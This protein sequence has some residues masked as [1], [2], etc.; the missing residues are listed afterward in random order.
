[1]SASAGDLSNA[2]HGSTRHSSRPSI[3]TNASGI[4]ESTI[5]FSQ[6]PAVPTE[7]PT[8]PIRA[9]FSNS[10]VRSNFSPVQPLVP[11]RG[12]LSASTYRN[13]PA[14]A[15]SSRSIQPR[16]PSASSS[17]VRGNP[18]PTHPLSP[19]DWHDGS[20]SIDGIDTQEARLL[21]TSF[22]TSLLQEN[23]EL[24]RQQ[25]SS[26]ASDAFS[27][28]SEL[29]Y[30]PSPPYPQP[31]S[32]RP[33][34]LQNRTGNPNRTHGTSRAPPSA[35]SP[36]REAPNR[37]ST[38]D[39]ETLHSTQGH[40]SIAGYTPNNPPVVVGVAQATLRS[41]P[42]SSRPPSSQTVPLSV[43]EKE[44]KYGLSSQDMDDDSILRFKAQNAYYPPPDPTPPS[45]ATHRRPNFNPQPS[46]QARQSTYSLAPS[47]VSK[48]SMASVGRMFHWRKKSLPPV[49]RIPDIPLAVENQTRRADQS[50]PLP[51]L[52]NR[53]DTLHALLEKGY[54]PHHSLSSYQQYQLQQDFPVSVEG[55]EHSYHQ[56]TVNTMGTTNSTQPLRPQYYSDFADRT[57]DKPTLTF[58][59]QGSPARASRLPLLSKRMKMGIAIFI[60]AAVASIIAAIV[61]VV[62]RNQSALPNC[63]NGLTGATCTLNSTC[64]CT[65]DDSRC[66]P[67]ARN[68]IDLIPSVN[69]A[70]SSNLT[71]HD[72]YTSLW[73]SQGRTR[74]NDCSPQ[75]LLVD[76]G[77][78]LKEELYPTRTQWVRAALLWNVV[79]AQDLQSSEDMLKF[80]QS[81]PWDSLPGD[82]PTNV[83]EE[84]FTASFSGFIYNFAAQTVTPISA[85]FASQGQPTREQIARVG[86]T[87]QSTLDRMYT[88]A[89]ASSVQRELALRNYW[90]TTLSQKSEDL[91]VFKAL[92][93]A[94]PILLPFDATSSSIR[95]LFSN[96]SSSLFPPP[97][98]CYPGLS[99]QQR[100][101]LNSL[102]TSVFQLPASETPSNFGTGCYPD[103]PIYGVLDV[104]RLRLPFLDSRSDLP[105]QGAILH[106]DAVPRVVIHSGEVLSA[107]FPNSQAP[108]F[109]A[110]QLDP[111]NFGTLNFSN[112]V[113]LRYLT[114][115]PVDTAILLVQYLLGI[116]NRPQAP[117]APSSPLFNVLATVP[118]IEVSIFGAVGPPDVA[119]TVSALA[120]TSDS[121]FYGSD[122]AAALRR[123]TISGYGGTVH[124][125]ERADAPRIVKDDSFN[126]QVMNEAWEA[127]AESIRRDLF[128]LDALVSSFEST[129]KFV[130]A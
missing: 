109:D 9:G 60:I 58:S 119:G 108:S 1:M 122:P 11:R 26:F 76:S 45:N 129:G 5:S 93:S 57:S 24:R 68:L 85:T 117:P 105:R 48:I 53:A 103:R 56:D 28:I 107:T 30:P 69:E 18:N 66:N 124:W 25:R 97:L 115:M 125:A 118:V 77:K 38:S 90:T 62:K 15:S 67:L 42:A 123:W 21:P 8:T 106:R 39:S 99:S 84:S 31:S 14:T 102:E 130:S 36:I 71:A 50:T 78:R 13:G 63:P 83:K 20:S 127:T 16:G 110:S 81:A 98:A 33:A 52:A 89:Q 112:H 23:K 64:V 94:S 54:H 32:G 17:T 87:A 22:I 86:S 80:V 4:A 121:M 79:Q 3:D 96:D 44:T 7:I 128:P 101:R 41:I 70:F 92:L 6:F 49:P 113:I 95:G 88:F 12:P 27:G 46:T 29:T 114:S 91:T 126:D 82:A 65:A 59:N 35:F 2:P 47:F 111:R 37:E 55:G 43:D 19:H 120:T 72:I 73:Y 116:S 74:S 10:P 34:I 104:L 75:A 40:P 51:D 100:D 61:V